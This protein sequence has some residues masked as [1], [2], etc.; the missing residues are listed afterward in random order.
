MTDTVFAK[1]IDREI[2][3]DIIYEDDTYLVFRDINPQAPTH[4]L[5]IPKVTHIESFHSVDNTED[6]EIVRW[7]FDI[8]WLLIKQYDLLWCK[9]QM[10]SW[11]THWQEVMHIHL[12]LLSQ[13]AIDS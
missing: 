8:A 3:A 12:H 7:L 2:P 9:L 1:I 6:Q 5:I 11:A 13:T 4:V 10:N